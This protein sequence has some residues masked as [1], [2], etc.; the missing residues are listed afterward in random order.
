MTTGRKLRENVFKRRL[1]DGSRQPG[2]WLTLESPTATEILAGAGYDWLLLDMEHTTVDPSQ[3][4]EHIRAACGGTAELAVRI[5]W[6]EPI[7][8]KRLLDAGVRT[9]MFPNVQSA[10]EAQAAVAATRY[11]PHGIRGVSGNMRANSYA[12]V[13]NYGETYRQEQC[14][15]VQLESPKAIAAIEEI[16]AIDGIDAL[17]IGP[18]DLAA[19]MGLFGQPGAP[20]VNA[21]ITGAVVRINKTGKAAGILNFN[22]AE[23]RALFKAGFAFI[24]VNSDTSILARRSEAILAEVK[25]E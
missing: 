17:F 19:S 11:P 2:L 13:K 20:A 3:V 4:A 8:V 12:R 9:L 16:A 24:A 5:P 7:M 22:I 21:V 14:L 25:A 10:A 1:G 15:I 18:N 6:N 23:A